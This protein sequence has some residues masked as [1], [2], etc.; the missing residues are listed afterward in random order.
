MAICNCEAV[1]ESIPFLRHKRKEQYFNLSKNLP[2]S[3]LYYS[4]CLLALLLLLKTKVYFSFLITIFNTSAAMFSVVKMCMFI[5]TFLYCAKLVSP[6]CLNL[7][8]E[9][10]ELTDVILSVSWTVCGKRNSKD[11]QWQAWLATGACPTP[12]TCCQ[13]IS[14][15]HSCHWNLR[16]S[17]TALSHARPLCSHRNTP[18]FYSLLQAMHLGLFGL[19]AELCLCFFF[20]RPGACPPKSCRRHSNTDSEVL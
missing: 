12:V 5:D 6:S 9:M 17:T 1:S 16:H 7:P 18:V 2:G 20:L 8:Q 19:K 10:A 15:K 14:G 11:L 13:I 3:M 4:I